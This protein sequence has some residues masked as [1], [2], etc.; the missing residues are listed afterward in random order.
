MVKRK[1]V[2]GR[3]RTAGIIAGILGSCLFSGTAMAANLAAGV[4]SDY[5]NSQLGVVTGSRVTTH[6][7]VQAQKG[8][9]KELNRDPAVYTYNLNG[10]S[11]LF[12]RQYTYSTT[13]LKNCVTFNSED[14]GN[15]VQTG[16]MESV[17]NAHAVTAANINN[18][19]YLYATGYDLGNIGVAQLSGNKIIEKNSKTVQLKEDITK[20]CG[21]VEG[22]NPAVHGEGISVY[23]GD[24]YVLASSNQNGTYTDYND[25]YVLQYHVNDDGS[26][27]YKSYTRMGKNSDQSRMNFYN[28]K[29]LISFIGGMQN[30]GSGNT[31]TTGIYAANLSGK[32]EEQLSVGA[33]RKINVPENV[34]ATQADFR[35]LKILPNGTAYVMTYNLSASS[36]NIDN[37]HVYQTTVS[38][39]LADKPQGWKEIL[40]TGQGEW[41]GWF[42]KLNAEYYTKRLWLEVGNQLKVYTDGANTPVVWDAKDLSTNEQYY[43]FNSLAL[44][45]PDTVWG[46]RAVLVAS[47]PEG[48]T[49]S[50]MV[51]ALAV[52]NN[53]IWKA[54]DAAEPIHD[55][56]TYTTDRVISLD[57]AAALGNLTT[58]VRAA[59]SADEQ[60]VTVNAA[61]HNLQ[62]QVRDYVGS[63]AGLYAGNGKT[64][65]VNADKL[66]IITE[67]Y[68]GGNSLT[69]AIW[70]DAA[71]DKA[72]NI[73]INAPVNI[74]MTGGYGGNGIAVQKT[75]RFGESSTEAG[76]ESGITI[77]GDVSIKG[78]TNAQWGIPLNTENVYSRF[79]NAGILTNV[80]NSRVTVD[81]N[82]DFDVYGNGVATNAEGSRV[83]LGGG[84]I[85]A[86]RGMNYGYYAL[87]AYLGN[88]NMNTGEDGKTPGTR[89]VQLNG[90]LFTLKTGAINLAL[91]TGDSWLKGI[92][93]NGGTANLYLQNGAAWYNQKN[94]TRY[95]EDNED[96]GAG[97]MSHIT[98]LIG[99][100]DK[101]SRGVIYQQDTNPLTIDN[102]SGHAV[103]VYAHDAAAPTV[104]KGG[105]LIINAAL[106]TDGSN[107]EMSLYTDNGGVTASNTDSVLNALA[108]KLIYTNYQNGNLTGRLEIGEGLT[109]ASV[110]KYITFTSA[111]GSYDA[112]A[113]E[114]PSTD[115]EQNKTTFTKQIS[116]SDIAEYKN[117]NVEKTPGSYT[118]TKDSVL[119]YKGFG[120]AVA[121]GGIPLAIDAADHTL[122]INVSN[123]GNMFIDGIHATAAK[124]IDI[125]AD[126]FIMNIN[127]DKDL[128]LNKAYGIWKQGESTT[129]IHGLTEIN[130]AAA[131][132]SY[133]VYASGY[134]S[135]IQLDGL[136]AAVNRDASDGLSIK[137]DGRGGSKIS[138]NV[139]DG[140]T[141]DHEVQLN[142]NIY[143]GV[144]GET[145][146]AL[147][148]QESLLNGVSIVQTETGS[149]D[150]DN[151]VTEAGTLNLYLQNGAVWTNENYS[152]ARMKGFSGSAVSN[153]TGGSDAAHAG[154]VFQKDAND[155]T[156]ASYSGNTKFLYAHDAAAPIT[157]L[158]GDVKIHKAAEGSLVTFITDHGGVTADN[159]NA[160]LNALANKLYYTGYI[161]GDRNL[162]GVAEI[163]EGLT[164]SSQAVTTG[165]ISFDEKTGQ[166]IYKTTPVV[167][168]D[169]NKAS[170]TAAL[171]GSAAADKEYSDANV[172]KADGSYVFTKDATSIATGTNLISGGIWMPKINAAVSNTDKTNVLKLDL[173][174]HALTVDTT[175]NTHSTGITAI[176][177]GTTL[178]IANAG[179]INVHAESSTGGMTAALYVNNGGVLNIHNG[180]GNPEDK[181]L[182]ARADT[183]NKA[184]GAVIKS[185]NGAAGRSSITIDGLVDV[186][187]DGDM[188]DGK[189]ANE[190]VSA[191]ASDIR[192]GGGT[193]R[194]INGAQQAIRA[195]GEFV[196]KNAGRVYV[197][198]KED[199]DGNAIGAGRNK[200]VIEGNIDTS[201][202][203]GTKGIV[204]IGLSTADSSWTGD[205]ILGGGSQWYKPGDNIGTVNLWLQNGAVWTGCTPGGKLTLLDMQNGAAWNNTG[206]ALVGTLKSDSTH[207]VINMSNAK[208]GDI[209]IDDYSGKA[210]AYYTHDRAVP[211]NINGG[212]ITISR[213]E[214]GSALTLRTD[215]AGLQVD[216]V[217]AA[218]KNL[219]SATLNAL[220]NKLYYTA[221]A[222][223]ETNLA[224]TAEIAEGLTSSIARRSVDIT[225][226]KA[227][228]GQGS[229]VYTPAAEPPDT[230]PITAAATLEKDRLAKAEEANAKG[231]DFV[232]AL[233]SAGNADKQHP[234]VVDMN[235]NSLSL[236]SASTNKRAATIYVGDNQSVE[237]K[238]AAGKT[239]QIK[240]SNT[241]TRAAN[242]IYMDAN[243]N[244]KLAGPVLI[245]QVSA[246]GD[247]ADGIQMNGT[248][249][250]T[251]TLTIDGPLTIRNVT[252]RETKMAGDGRNLA[253]IDIV[254]DNDVVTVNGSVDIQGLKGSALKIKGQ[255]AVLS[256]GGGTI[257]AAEDAS[258]SKR[259][260]AVYAE[261]GTVN[262]NMQSGAAGT[263]RTNLTGDMYLTREYGQKTVEYSGGQ[264]IAYDNKGILNAALTTADSTWHG[265]ATY[266]IDKSDYGTG[267]FTAH[268]V[269]QFNLWLQN[270]A[271]WT[272]EVMSSTAASFAGSHLAA[273]HGGSDASHAG[274]IFQKDDKDILVDNYSGNTTVLYTHD[275]ANPAAIQGGSLRIN[276][277]AAGSAVTLRTDS[278]GL[279]TE[280]LKAADENLVSAALNALANKLYYTAYA[281]GE[282]NLAGTVEIAEGLTA[283]AASRKTGTITYRTEDGQGSYVYTPA[284]DIPD[285]QGKTAFTSAITGKEASDT[286]Y[287]NAGVRKGDGS[288]V[289]TKEA[290]SV[291]AGK[292]IVATGSGWRDPHVS[293]A[294]SNTDQSAALN[295]NLNQ[296]QLTIQTETD[297][298][299][300]GITAAQGAVVNLNGAGPVS[301][302]A[303]GLNGGQ[304]AALFVNQGGQ[305]N[306]HNGDGNKEDKILTLRADS[307]IAG[308]GAAIKS[309]NGAAGVKS[310]INIDGLVD[311][312]ADGDTSD[313]YGANEAVSAV[314]SDINIGGGS[315]R[316]INGAAYAIR[317]Y[318]EFTS[319][320]TGTVNVNVQKDADGKA[321][322]AGDNKAVL[323]G[324]VCTAG[325][326]GNRGSI[327]IGLGTKDSSWT[328]NYS[329]NGGNVNLF[330]KNGASWTGFNTGMNFNLTM[331][332]S[333][334]FNTG[335][336]SLSRL[337]SA[338]G[339]I[340]MTG[341][342]AGNVNIA[343]YSGTATVLY[344]HTGTV[345]NGGSLTIARADAGSK[346]TLQTDNTGLRMDDGDSVLNVLDG[347]ANKLTYTAYTTGERNLNGYVKIAEGLTASSAGKET[348][349]IAFNETTG[350]GS[351][352]KTTVAPNPYPAKQTKDTF[353]GGIG[354]DQDK[355]YRDDGV[356]KP[357]GSY[358]FSEDTTIQAS[359]KDD[360][361]GGVT[362]VAGKDQAIVIRAGEGKNLHFD[363]KPADAGTTAYGI[364]SASDKGAVDITADTVHVD[365]TAGSRESAGILAKD[366]G[367]V[368]VD[369]SVDIQAGEARG[370]AAGTGADM[371][372]LGGGV[373]HGSTAIQNDGGVISLG[374]AKQNLEITGNINNNGGTVTLGSKA[375]DKTLTLNG[376]IRNTAGGQTTIGAEDQKVTM[377][378]DVT[379]TK[380]E[381][382]INLTGAGS[383]LTGGIMTGQKPAARIMLMRANLLGANLPLPVVTNTTLELGADA[384]WTNTNPVEST[385]STLD[386]SG[387]TI[388]QQS[389]KT[390]TVGTLSGSA[391][392]SYASTY[393]AGALNVNSNLGSFI[394]KDVDTSRNN[395]ITIKTDNSSLPSAGLTDAAYKTALTQ[396]AKK[397]TYN[398]KTADHLTGYAK[399]NES[400]TS[401]WA[402]AP[403][404]FKA[405]NGT[406]CIGAITTGSAVTYGAYETQLMSGV[407]SAM[408]SSTMAWRASGNDLMKRMG[409]LRLSAGETGAWS[410][411]YRGKSSYDKDNANY[412]LNYSTV[413][414]G[415]DKKVGHDWR[416]GAALSYM[417]GSSGYQN[418][419]NGK[420]H[421][422]DLGIYGTWQGKGG[423]YVDLILK[424][425]RLSNEYTTY[426]EDGHKVSGD[427]HTLGLSMSAE[428]GRRFRQKGGFYYEP[429][430]ELTY[431]HLNGADYT[432]HSDFSDGLGGYRNMQVSQSSFN[433]LIGRAGLGIGMETAHSTWFAKVSLNHEFCGS[434]STSY[435]ADS[436][437]KSTH[438]SFGDT[439][440]S[441]QLGGTVRLS[442]SLNFYGD[443]EKTAGGDVKTDWRVD[444]GLRWS[445]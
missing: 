165:D 225:F 362:A 130:A 2:L 10:Q 109:S 260:A 105:D 198:V 364:V 76:E 441:F 168:D 264:L 155:L 212:S 402:S 112:K 240:A 93:D 90:D 354:G 32:S 432:A 234:M 87:A 1:N 436:I 383:H 308:N 349:S 113:P 13:A 180:D 387:G 190:A 413:Q 114:P 254:A 237:I 381:V 301:I 438:Q 326:M 341:A 26:L 44:L 340:D 171:T 58:N 50:S 217:Q 185:M 92:V 344:G 437:L 273:L 166:G 98:N 18:K 290:S 141:G 65:T 131:S 412:H 335:A 173:K 62:L 20:Y 136:K 206:A 211:T 409:D 233:Y 322:G 28:D 410:R 194:A 352:D 395:T 61:G 59:A 8:V 304:T 172:R 320:N 38:N 15:A 96:V 439:W 275:A 22:A 327:N 288:Y 216:S 86:P 6:V 371:Q 247:A 338:N 267:G 384:V 323:E 428:Y 219:V 382:V 189:G 298:H 40:S 117:A 220:A 167:S 63:P 143:T 191:V 297:T 324:D 272:N 363:A 430:A 355:K 404:E 175:A 133:G 289:F 127:G 245:D 337:G 181:I 386:G 263:V 72:S 433:S 196:T 182:T 252:G 359:K 405:D 315:I 378:G 334:W 146:L 314:A 193:I 169:Q 186:L 205:Y 204:N 102:F 325:G 223:G 100:K 277:A 70:N 9:I 222:A 17:A 208:S 287:T 110:N 134:G 160:V 376:D 305:I 393:A 253:G 139:K 401:A 77:H 31:Q 174:G 310:S 249:G 270:G 377:K 379:N 207:N 209:T 108:N 71:K 350:Q 406:N 389:A 328:G 400:M 251:S 296:H 369:G 276:K 123:D 25:G 416:V 232:S 43:Q 333:S 336:G 48:L 120:G 176:G 30:Y 312:L 163:A 4:A 309:M 313:G 154:V 345:I 411:V 57:D 370:L 66:N 159:T 407:K 147:T 103:T 179:K 329:T 421:D 157:M 152:S 49:S 442:D 52:N 440:L 390:I 392:V 300:T 408:T 242:G 183:T 153:F 431:S 279:N 37:G 164:A 280:S 228:K 281:T 294:I 292:N 138:V 177:T 94:N 372:L 380:G 14:L 235:G 259:Y 64:L 388:E 434:L 302:T 444:A 16:E 5:A 373:I 422:T 419:G 195:Y 91:T 224:G 330:M 266:G 366:N 156:I 417:E 218:D 265:A 106:K 116:G 53:A 321:V 256:V 274:V 403:I 11:G 162:K 137:S 356:L 41:A 144:Y 311:V 229:Y 27:T 231:G 210:M 23:G 132:S 261:K 188:A 391:V 80:N 35:D 303:K 83:T 246:K 75:D 226:D 291:T 101:A 227:N 398:G 435:D 67:G 128:S 79:N 7:D 423:Q 268:D 397:L 19:S 158:G 375:S 239:L 374:N 262:I 3:R 258:H 85:T 394:L 427:Y 351:V 255:D 424:A 414:I 214:A 283:S 81:G 170:F 24:L 29:L 307:E 151:P 396:L 415:Y 47:A 12:L 295:I 316:A 317:A 319:T 278:A 339:V 418:G 201:G 358:E 46:N 221:S 119:N 51:T 36:G 125:T 399:I 285:T 145:N 184:N 425:G 45:Q 161:S 104:I 230:S 213:A 199:A 331:A 122:T 203:M 68:E 271:A 135:K 74:S 118:F 126:K 250:A 269:G 385:I 353:D 21:G 426:N 97:Q 142:G 78:G 445:F 368:K 84:R 33:C 306:I 365:V 42:G 361:I 346:I 367:Q 192:I 73:I 342:A 257:T 107:A 299:T 111:R 244:L 88:I 332:D 150:D 54:G 34:K 187:A 55:S 129:T 89:S 215:N 360:A 420:N 293:A 197:N 429:Q 243:A 148:T 39:L 238:N 99:G 343:D 357:D 318:G 236:E 56:V 286:E 202:G 149:D 60:D 348:G 443:F 284:I 69:N 248:I 178:D 115:T 282:R 347:L 241:D 124:N 82:V 140:V 200:T 95:S 121:D